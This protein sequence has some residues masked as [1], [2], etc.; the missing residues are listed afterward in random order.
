MRHILS[1]PIPSMEG[2]REKL[3]IQSRVHVCCDRAKYRVSWENKGGA[4]ITGSNPFHKYLHL[5][6]P[7]TELTG[8]ITFT[9][10]LVFWEDGW[11]P[12]KASEAGGDTHR[13]GKEPTA[14]EF[15]L[16][17]KDRKD[18]KHGRSLGRSLTGWWWGGEG[19]RWNSTE[20]VPE[21]SR[22][23]WCARKRKNQ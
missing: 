12:S 13:E 3:T 14:K 19:S 4:P 9:V 1:P 16:V 15:V 22:N 6:G 17:W 8:A 21:Y 11:K 23:V 7:G 10:L 18:L 5:H 2:K 20:K